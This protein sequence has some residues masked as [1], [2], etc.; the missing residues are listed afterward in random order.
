VPNVLREALACGTPFVA[1]RVGGT[2]EIVEPN[3]RLVPPDDPDLLADAIAEVLTRELPVT[4][5]L[6][7][8]M[9]WSDSA[10]ALLR[11]V[12]PLLLPVR[13]QQS[14]AEP[15]R[16]WPQLLKG[17][18]AALLPRNLL[19]LRAPASRRS[20]CLTFDDGPHP[21]HTPRLLEVLKDQDVRATFFVVGKNAARYPDLV[22]WIAAEGHTIGNHSYW[23]GKPEQTS[24]GT[25]LQEVRQTRD[26]LGELLGQPPNLF[27]PPHGKLTVSKLWQLWKAGQTVVLWSV[28]PK[29]FAR[30]DHREIRDWFERRPLHAG[31]VV[32]MHDNHPHAAAVVPQLV[33]AGRARGLSFTTLEECLS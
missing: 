22:R 7:R 16:T 21:E 24:A 25:L 14:P 4:P 27:R 23:H 30:T 20:V 31:D 28:D 8:Q 2:P 32:L 26:L 6:S 17:A 33:R 29:D 19:L 11:V 3:S 13:Q 10:E 12:R 1:S 9:T 18:L 5:S 15:A